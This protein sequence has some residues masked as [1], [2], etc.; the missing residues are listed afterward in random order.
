MIGV[1]H[2]AP[3]LYIFSTP[4]NELEETPVVVLQGMSWQSTPLA[5]ASPIDL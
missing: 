1:R 4:L 2:V 3:A 5:E